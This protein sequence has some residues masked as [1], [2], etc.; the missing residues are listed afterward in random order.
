MKNI[1]SFLIALIILSFAAADL[2]AQQQVMV[3]DLHTY[4]TTPAS[5]AD[6]PDH[7]LTGVEVEFD[8]V[9]VSYPKN[10]G[11][12]SITSAG[13]P[14]RIHVFVTDVNAIDEGREGNSIQIV[15]EGDQRETLEGLFTGDVITVT[16]ELTF[17]GNVSQFNA[18]DVEFVGTVDT[19]FPDLAP[20]LEPSVIN[21]TDINEPSAIDGQ[22]RWIA[23]N[24]TTY[25]NR[26]VKL[27]GLEVIAVNI[28]DTGRPWYILTDGT[29]IITSNDTSLRFRNDRT[30]YAYDPSEDEGLGYNYRR[31]A[32]DLDGPF[33]PPAPGSIVDI[34]GFIVVNTFDPGDFDEAT[35][36]STFKIAPWDDGV[37]WQNDGDD[38]NDRLTPEGW[39]NDFVVL[40]FAPIL[41]DFEVS[42]DP[43]ETQIF[44]DTEV[45]VSVDVLLPEVDYTLESVQIEYMI[46]PY[47]DDSSDLVVADMTNTSG[48]T[49]TFT[50]DAQDDF[51]TVEFQVVATATTPNGVET[52]GR[53]DGSYFVESASQTSPV[54]FS[55]PAGDYSTAISVE[56][57]SATSGA[58]IHY[59]LDGSTPDDSSPVYTSAIELIDGATITALATSAELDNS[60]VNSRTYMVDVDLIEVETMAELRAGTQGGTLYQY[61]GDAVVTY[62]RSTRN[63]KYLM[64]DT[65]GILIDDP[66]TVITSPYQIGDVMTGMIGSL[67][68]FQGVIQ[69]LPGS[70]PGNPQSTMDVV[71]QSIALNDITIAD[72]ESMLILVEDV[73]FDTDETEFVGGTNYDLVDSSLDEGESVDFRT[74]FPESNYIGQPIPTGEINLT[75]LVGNF[76]GN[77]QLIARSDADFGPPTSTEDGTSPYRFQLSQNYPNPFNPATRIN[78]ELAQTT[79][80]RLVV[81]DILGRRVAT[82]VNE[83]QNAGLHTVNF[84][85]SRYASGTYIYRLEAGDF[86]SVKKMML[87]K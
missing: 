14:G 75:A 36:Q 10:S 18:T 64:D 1:Y 9:I 53:E 54:M 67:G 29:T 84:D 73:M 12:A 80:V 76:N 77:I 47:T 46:Y 45:T 87:I 70:N 56:L 79:D 27:E 8:A 55:P 7:P 86:V 81:Y 28:Q 44:N 60:P 25:I 24:Y 85:M 37:V 22:H 57:S 26:Y 61:T 15:V 42:P 2:F 69:F 32:T 33:T 11:L 72:H 21:L 51:T 50:F 82:L 40:G 68:S 34:S 35:A 62:A 13:V 52:F 39:P 65:G 19:D 16:G 3:R 17:F 59:T 38:P 83:V 43:E 31:L 58:T 74:N 5:Q 49:Y 4:D 66:G 6:L 41:T 30:N 23:E 71:P 20:L 48:D 63:Q 78:Y